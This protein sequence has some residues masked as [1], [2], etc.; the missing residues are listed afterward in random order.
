[1]WPPFANRAMATALNGRAHLI[2]VGQAFPTGTRFAFGWTVAATENNSLH[3][4]RPPASLRAAL[5]A[6]LCVRSFGVA[7]RDA[8][9][10]GH[11]QPFFADQ[12]NS[13]IAQGGLGIV[14]ANQFVSI[15]R[16]ANQAP[17][18]LQSEMIP[19]M[20]MPSERYLCQ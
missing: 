13:A 5:R 3:S 14:V 4:L 12:G 10:I 1:M 11:D 6:G 17:N 8:D 20:P 7:R 9:F 19:L 18:G 15:E 16:T 2:P